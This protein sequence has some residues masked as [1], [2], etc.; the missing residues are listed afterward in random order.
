MI[1]II[2]HYIECIRNC[3][4]GCIYIYII[5]DTV[6]YVGFEE[7]SYTVNEGDSLQACVTIKSGR[8]L[9]S[10]ATVTITSS[11]GTARGMYIVEPVM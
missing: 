6:T 7:T 1:T 8:P 4:T 3:L 10:L 2:E 9:S 11:S 5:S